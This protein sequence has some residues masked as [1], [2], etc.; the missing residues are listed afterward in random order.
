MKLAEQE[1]LCIPDFVV[2]IAL[3]VKQQRTQI[4]KIV[5]ITTRKLAGVVVAL[6]VNRST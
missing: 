5:E 1:D 6:L 4:W 3:Q 2:V